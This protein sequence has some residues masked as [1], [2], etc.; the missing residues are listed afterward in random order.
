MDIRAE[1]DGEVHAERSE[2]YEPPMLEEIGEF[3]A[4][5]RADS[6]GSVVDGHGYYS[7]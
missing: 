2:V 6:R 5:T 1:C 4:L 7:A 3:T